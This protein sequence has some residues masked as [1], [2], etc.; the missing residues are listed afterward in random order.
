[1]ARI[2]GYN[3]DLSRCLNAHA[4]AAYRTSFGLTENPISEAGRWIN[5]GLDWTPVQ[6]SGGVAFRTQVGG[7]TPPADFNDSYAHLLGFRPNHMAWAVLQLNSPDGASNHEFEL[8][9]RMSDSAHVAQG[10]ECNLAW[11]GAYTTIVR[12]DNGLGQFTTLSQIST[13]LPTPHTGDIFLAKMVGNAISVYL[14]GTLINSTTD[15]TYSAGNPGMGF[16]TSAPAT[17]T[18]DVAFSFYAAQDL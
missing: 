16:F 11:N 9:L 12:W 5:N 1:M 10:Y 3:P 13:G 14:N 4:P 17:P 6:T 18:N 15:T 8:F 7:G 2:L